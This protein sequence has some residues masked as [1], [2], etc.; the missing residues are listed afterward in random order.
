MMGHC[1]RAVHER[2]GA[3]HFSA[4]GSVGQ[5]RAHSTVQRSGDGVHC[6]LPI[7]S[8]QCTECA[9]VKMADLLDAIFL[10]SLECLN[11]N[12]QHPLAN[13]L[14]QVPVQRCGREQSS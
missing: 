3:M 11:Q 7:A 13:A 6:M 1:G 9:L 4:T 10:P 5:S 14:K 2:L 12:D 8:L